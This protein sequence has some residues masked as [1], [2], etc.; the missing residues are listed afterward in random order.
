MILAMRQDELVRKTIQPAIDFISS[1]GPKEKVLIVYGHDNDSICSAVLVHMLLKKF[2]KMDSTFFSTRD[3]FAVSEEDVQEMQNI[4]HD[5]VI[6]VD[7]SHLASESVADFLSKRKTL[8]IDHHQPLKLPGITYCNPRVYEKEIYMPVSYI[9]YKIHQVSGNET[10]AAWIAG[11]G[12][13]SDHAVSIAHDLFEKIKKTNPALIGN[14]R[15]SEEDLFSFSVIGTLAKTLDSARI[16]KGRAGAFLAASTLARVR[17]YQDMIR[18]STDGA[19]QLLVWAETV[20]KEFHRLVADFNLRRNIIKDNIIFYEIQSKLMIK[21]SLAGYI[22]QFYKDKI[23][24]IAQENGDKLDFSF[25]RGDAVKTDLNKMAKGAIKDIP[26][27][28]GGGH[29]AA[30]AARIPKRYLPKFLKQL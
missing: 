11:I 30:S 22:A 5:T 15:L 23:L 29:E 14:T 13:L 21:S 17:S 1:V 20:N 3:N 28:D 18:G 12:V 8:I 25:R 16:M 7:I 6:I 26:D 9:M 4:Q 10:D 27:S 24:V 2:K 19:A